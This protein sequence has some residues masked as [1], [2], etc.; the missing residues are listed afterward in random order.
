MNTNDN[1]KTGATGLA[2]ATVTCSCSR[3]GVECKH[4]DAPTTVTKAQRSTL[5][6]CIDLQAHHGAC[7]IFPRG[8][9]QH[10]SYSRLESMGLLRYVGMGCDIDGE[11]E[12]EVPIYEITDAG[13]AAL[14][15]TG[16]RHG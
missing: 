14:A 10:R 13:R 16:A 8:S 11:V 7:G 15:A 12:H 3:R 6:R 9:S 2:P 1:T 5:E 4:D